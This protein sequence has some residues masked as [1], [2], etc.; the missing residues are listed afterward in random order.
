MLLYQHPAA[1]LLLFACTGPSVNADTTAATVVPSSSTIPAPQTPAGPPELELPRHP[2]LSPDASQVAFSHQGDIWVA[3]VEGGRAVRLTAH[4]AYDGRPKW[5]PDGQ[6]LAFVSNRHGNWDVYTMPVWGGTPNR[7]T[8]HSEGERLYQWLD[9]DRLLI[10]AQYDRRYSRRDRGAWI[11]YTD[12]RT[13]TVLGDWAIMSASVSQDGNTMVYERG[14][15]DPARRAYRGPAN[16]SLWTYDMVSNLH[17]QITEFEGNDLAPMLSPDGKTVY[18]LS[19]RSCEGNLEGRDLGLWKMPVKGGRARLVYHPGGRSLRNAALSQDG[20]EVV[21]E[22][23]L[24]LVRIATADGTTNALP[25]FG[26]IDPSDPLVHDKTVSGGASGITLSPDGESIAFVSA[27]DVYVMRKHEDIKRCVR[28]T[29]HPAPDYSPV[30]LDGGEELL[31]VSERDG[32][33]EFYIA[34]VPDGDDADNE[35]ES[36]GEDADDDEDEAKDDA[37]TTP[38]YMTRTFEIERLTQTDLD[39]SSPAL[40]PDGETLA[41]IVGLGDLVVG[42]PETA[43]VRRTLVTGFEAPNFDWSPDSEWLVYSKSDDDFNN[44]V[45]LQRV[46][47]EGLDAAEPGVLPYNLTVHPDDDYGP[48]WSPDG[49]HIT[50]TSRRMMLDETDVWMVHLR[51]EDLEMNKQERLE[52]AEAKKKAAKAKKGKKSKSEASSSNGE[53]DPLITGTWEGNVTGPEPI[54]PTGLPVTFRLLKVGDD[55]QGEMESMLFS[56]SC[57]AL[58]WDEESGTLSFTLAI[59][60]GPSGAVTLNISGEDLNGV[61]IVEGEEFPI[62]G[63]RT[64]A[65]SG[66]EDDDFDMEDEDSSAEEAAQDAP[67]AEKKD[68]EKEDAVIIDWIDLRHRVV[69][70][71]RREGNE[72]VIGW[73]ADSEKLYFNANTG[74]RLTNGTSAESGFFSL[75]IDG[76]KEDKV[77]ST[78]VA[79]LTLS[80]KDL[81]YVKGGR[82]ISKGKTYS[83]S[84]RFREDLRAVRAEVLGEVWRAL[85]RNFYDPEFHG[86]DWAASLAKWGPAARAASTRED[87]GEMVNWMLGEM[88]ASHMGYYSFGSSA[89]RETDAPGM[90]MLG[91]LWD[92]SHSGD[93][94]R[95]KTVLAGTP[96]AR[97]ISQLHEGDIVLS[98][99]GEAYLEG[100]NWQRLMSGTSGRPTFLEV[101][102]TDLTLREVIMRPTGSINAALYRR[103]EDVTRA[104][105]EEASGGRLGYIHIESMSTGPLVEFERDLF[106]AGAGKDALLIDV[107]ENGG[108]WTTDMIL[109]MLTV[110]DHALTIPRGGGEGYP[111]GRRVFATWDKPIVVLCNENS[112]SNAEIFSWAI[113]T[114]GRGPLVGKATFGAVISTGGTSLMDGSFVRL[115][116]RGWYVNDKNHTNMELNGCPV[117]YPVENLPGDGLMDLDRQLEKAIKVG[118]KQL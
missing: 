118:L 111:Q 103:F 17:K 29:T 81:F 44:D 47:I 54:P 2:A 91:V 71:T 85:D 23:D 58:V 14:H 11:A 60:D 90:G 56:A 18:F 52:A 30:W 78:P 63:K 35:K 67:T 100:G 74:T 36:G 76:G 55:I 16:S 59:P 7:L 4:D 99:N 31:F 87:Y 38:F 82:I 5:S 49:R 88:N 107:R 77:E 72:T 37:E 80:D 50:F 19:D 68:G 95:V 22:L 89:A 102:G 28:V 66:L 27:G 79:S 57:E 10:G 101:M 62:S 51:S 24:G 73:S 109:S 32:N 46:D 6:S 13:P 110:R 97:S 96:A 12:G 42:N 113:K 33:A 21:A 15:G 48:H 108:G 104:R 70:M 106:A 112:Y 75:E 117:D 25:V 116:F 3:P 92:E 98:V 43:E 93:G 39:E 86:H 34:E 45:F 1:L 64:S 20:T 26:S 53:A 8:W 9:S 41:W 94:R 40:S 84:V 115:P 65:L 114:L 69:R 83:F 105:V 61:A